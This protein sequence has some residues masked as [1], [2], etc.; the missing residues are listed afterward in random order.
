MD[1]KLTYRERFVRSYRQLRGRHVD[2]TKHNWQLVAQE[3][4]RALLVDKD[5]LH[6][7]SYDYCHCWARRCNTCDT[8][9][10]MSDG[11]DELR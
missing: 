8:V 9:Q 11:A 1:A 6:R 4:T 5:G 7:C 2:G 10:I 3:E